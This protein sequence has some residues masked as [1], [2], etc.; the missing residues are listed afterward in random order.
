M[1]VEAALLRAAAASGVPVA[2]VV[3][4]AGDPEATASGVDL[5]PPWMVVRRIDG[6]TVPRRVFR[7]PAL[8]AARGRMVDDCGAALAAIHGVPVD[9]IAGLEAPDR[10]R[11]YRDLLDQF[12][13]HYKMGIY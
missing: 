11:Q 13:V 8:E 9:G 5:G 2:D 10:M 3:V 12:G 7:D 6:E 4:A 1:A